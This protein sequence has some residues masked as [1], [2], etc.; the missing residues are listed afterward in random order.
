M[1]APKEISS[2]APQALP[3]ASCREG[4]AVAQLE[5]SPVIVPS[6][7]TNSTGCAAQPVS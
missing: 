6:D 3:S 5:P 7:E 1:L 4:S 2:A